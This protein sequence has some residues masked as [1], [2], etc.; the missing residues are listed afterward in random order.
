MKSIA[1]EETD[2]NNL[3]SNTNSE[4]LNEFLSKYE[5]LKTKQLK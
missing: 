3:L 4:K 2:W 1:T 5:C